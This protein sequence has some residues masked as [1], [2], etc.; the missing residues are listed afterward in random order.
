[1]KRTLNIIDVV[2]LNLVQNFIEL[3]SLKTF[4]KAIFYKTLYKSQ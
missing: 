1:M 2:Q 4:I 3:C